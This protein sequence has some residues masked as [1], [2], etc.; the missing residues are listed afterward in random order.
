MPEITKSW[1]AIHNAAEESE[2]AELLLYGFIGEWDEISSREVVNALSQI[3]AKIINVKVNSYGGSVFTAQAIFSAL[4]RHAAVINVFI[5]GIAA[6]AASIIICAGN[7]VVI[8]ANAMMMIHNPRMYVCG[9]AADLRDS[10]DSL[11]KVRDSIIAAYQTKTAL[12][13]EKLVELMEAETWLN[14]DEAVELGFADDVENAVRI[15]ASLSDG[16]VTVNGLS[17]D[18]SRF[19]SLPAALATPPPTLPALEPNPAAPAAK[20]EDETV[21]LDTLKSKH[22]DLYEEIIN[23]GKATGQMAERQRIQAIENMAPAGH[24]EL[25]NQAKFET[26][27][28]AST[29]AMEILNAEKGQNRAYLENRQDDADALRHTHDNQFAPTQQDEQKKI[30]AQAIATGFTKN[31]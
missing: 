10:A 6:S 15:A 30:I 26:G 7:N 8:P 21:D 25:V 29:L 19:H 11:D 24:A 13:A 31:R 27:V 2:A 5:D 23:E 14:A 12:S 20:N 28:P 18:A 4:K 3:T 9:D 16:V 22:P 17:F 1:W